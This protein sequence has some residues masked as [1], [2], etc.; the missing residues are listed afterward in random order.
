MHLAQP[1]KSYRRIAT[2][3]AP[4][5]QLILMLLDGAMRSLERALEGFNHGDPAQANMAIHNNLHRA[6]EIIHELDSCL[7][8]EQGGECA[9]TLRG[10]YRYFDR[11]LSESN[12]HKHGEGAR[13]VLEHLSVLRDAWATMLSRNETTP[14]LEPVSQLELVTV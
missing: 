6:Q 7:N 1:W 9:T 4:P 12:I 5:G 2:Q 3:T 10:L 13:E 14:S 8:M 11:R